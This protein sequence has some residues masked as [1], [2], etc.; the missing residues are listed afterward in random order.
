MFFSLTKTKRSRETG[1][2]ARRPRRSLLLERMEDR[3]LLSLPTGTVLVANS[4]SVQSQP[5]FTGLSSTPTG[6]IAVD[7][8]IPVAYDLQGHLQTNQPNQSAFS[9]RDG[10]MCTP[11]SLATDNQGNFFVADRTAFGL[12]AGGV[13]KVDP[14][15]GAES[16]I[17]ADQTLMT[18]PAG[19]IYLNGFLYVVCSGTA[20]YGTMLS[21][22]VPNTIG[23]KQPDL[24]KIN[25]YADDT[26]IPQGGVQ[27][28]VA[29][30]ATPNL[31]VSD[32][33]HAKARRPQRA[34]S[35][36]D[37]QHSPYEPSRHRDGHRWKSDCPEPGWKPG[38]GY[39]LRHTN[40]VQCQPAAQRHEGGEPHG[41]PNAGPIPRD[42]LCRCD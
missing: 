20:G 32:H 4:P 2:E 22:G 16:V 27:T 10:L 28:D 36:M 41:G 24:V 19:I 3:T 21:P 11:V 30:G 6:L 8:T 15:T 35:A 42:D 12:G 40:A 29:G 37:Q 34:N 5:K 17:A 33:E 18:G 9:A 14:G 31:E 26:T 25:P 13:I 38:S 23:Q 39:P 1:G 7:P